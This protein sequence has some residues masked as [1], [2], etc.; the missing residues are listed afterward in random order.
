MAT[1]GWNEQTA[2]PQGSSESRVI[3]VHRLE[4]ALMFGLFNTLINRGDG[5]NKRMP[6]RISRCSGGITMLAG[7]LAY[8]RTR[9]FGAG[10]VN[11][12]ERH[13]QAGAGC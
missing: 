3:F 11:V 8:D 12:K 6:G 7:W 9:W 4:K 10:L 5:M 1:A 2:S 13:L